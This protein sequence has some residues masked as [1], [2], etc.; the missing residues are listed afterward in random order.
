MKR[1]I[2]L[3]TIV[4]FISSCGLLTNYTEG[5]YIKITD[6]GRMHSSGGGE[7]PRYNYYFG[8][9]PKRTIPKGWKVVVK[10]RSEF[11][12]IN[13]IDEKTISKVFKSEV[14]PFSE[15]I[16]MNSETINL[17]N[18]LSSKMMNS[19]MTASITLYDE[20]NNIIEQILDYYDWR[21]KN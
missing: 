3:L 1:I 13:R 8:F 4:L 11:K 12:S 10:F 16:Y 17:E 5:Q 15:E 6:A 19:P 20:K 14:S 9:V 18:S 7:S 21:W 2:F